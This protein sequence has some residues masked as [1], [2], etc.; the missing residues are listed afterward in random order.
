MSSDRLVID[1]SG[2]INVDFV[3]NLNVAGMTAGELSAAL[4]QKLAKDIRNPQVAVNVVE[5]GSQRVT[6]EGSVVHPGIYVVPPGTTL[7]GALATAGDPDRFGRVR[8][9]V[10]FRKESAGRTVAL[11]DLHAIRDGRMMD[12][13][14]KAND[15]IIV[16]VSGDSRLY[17][18]LLQ[19]VPAFAIFSR[20]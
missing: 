17:Q 18:D 3:G 16:G 2:T 6:V 15:R 13:V 7:L 4:T 20:F 8:K 10:I 9:I 11:F 12:P 5:F 19:L 14:V 1:Q